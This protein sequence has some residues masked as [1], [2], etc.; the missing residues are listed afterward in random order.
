MTVYLYF[1][2]KLKRLITPEFGGLALN[3]AAGYSPCLPYR[4]GGG[5][6]KHRG[7]E[8]RSS[9]V[10]WVVHST[11]P[12]AT[13]THCGRAS[14]EGQP[15]LQP[16][17]PAPPEEGSYA[18]A[19]GTTGPGYSRP[20]VKILQM[21]IIMIIIKTQVDIKVVK[22]NW[23][24]I[25]I[26]LLY[27]FPTDG[28]TSYMQHHESCIGIIW[29]QA[30]LFEVGGTQKEQKRVNRANFAFKCEWQAWNCMKSNST[31]LR[32]GHFFHKNTKNT[33]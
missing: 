6:S 26:S 20:T 13:G 30:C 21:I 18:Y 7:S 14:P 11:K 12:Q 16:G 2:Q 1:V 32:S 33:I 24:S 25:K 15:E 9:M 4:P 19:A 3:W 5:R 31:V 17:T 22:K 8:M 10:W 28:N 29:E 23:V 27:E